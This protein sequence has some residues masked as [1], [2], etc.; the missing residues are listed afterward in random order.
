[1]TF[2]LAVAANAGMSFTEVTVNGAS[3]VQQGMLGVNG[4]TVKF[5][6]VGSKVTGNGKSKTIT[7]GYIVTSTEELTGFT[8]SPLGST[9]KGNVS[10]QL[11]HSGIKDTFQWGSTTSS[12]ASLA[13]RSPE[14]LTSLYTYKVQAKIDLSTLST[15]P[16]NRF[17]IASLSQYN[18]SYQTASPV[19]EPASLAV[20]GIGIAGL[21]GRRRRNRA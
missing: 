17:G 12:V 18:I 5:D 11:D 8:F 14:T 16:T 19:P 9:L 21:L 15:T 2:L 1:M 20:V 10:V 7:L 3:I 6:A 4:Y 13:Q